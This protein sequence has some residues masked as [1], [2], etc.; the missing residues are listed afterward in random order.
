MNIEIAHQARSDVV[1]M[2]KLW[3]S[4]ECIAGSAH[5]AGSGDHVTGSHLQLGG[6]AHQGVCRLPGP[7]DP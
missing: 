1:L 3:L 2:T 7:T 5:F 4:T 6:P